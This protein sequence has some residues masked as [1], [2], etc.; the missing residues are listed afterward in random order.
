MR[1]KFPLVLIAAALVISV[2]PP[3]LFIF[4][5]LTIFLP[6]NYCGSV[7]FFPIS[8][9]LT[10]R[11]VWWKHQDS[12]NHQQQHQLTDVLQNTFHRKGDRTRTDDRYYDVVGCKS[13]MFDVYVFVESALS[14]VVLEHR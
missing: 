1:G 5:T 6:F 14:F 11:K 12:G 13:A 10:I 2:S 8:T 4:S 7:F 3:S 9:L